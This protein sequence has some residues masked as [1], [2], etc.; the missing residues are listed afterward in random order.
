M[1]GVI[2]ADG[3]QWERCNGCTEFT[4]IEVMRYE[5]PSAQYKYGRDLCPNC[6]GPDDG[7]NIG[8][9]ITLPT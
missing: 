7:P 9:T 1:S 5:Q 4:R 6:A 3:Q 8:V 2:D